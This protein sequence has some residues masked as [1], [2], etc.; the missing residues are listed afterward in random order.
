MTSALS[1]GVNVRNTQTSYPDNAIEK[2]STGYI[3]IILIAFYP[4]KI[5]HLHLF[6][7][8]LSIH[9]N[10]IILLDCFYYIP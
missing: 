7:H 3:Y 2:V 9:Q 4:F 8:R 5:V 10:L 1:G 6:I